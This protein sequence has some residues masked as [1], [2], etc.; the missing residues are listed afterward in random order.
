MDKIDGLKW[1]LHRFNISISLLLIIFLSSCSSHVSK[2]DGPPNFYVDESKIPNAKP[3]SEPLSKYGN[4]SSYRVFGKRYFVMK[5]GQ[6]YDEV[7]TASWYGTKFHTRRTSSGEPYNMLAMTAA[8]KSLPLP[9]YVEVTNLDNQRKIIV[10]VNDRGPFL[11]NRIIDLSYVAAKKLGML[12]RGTA[13]VRVKAINPFTFGRPT[14]FSKFLRKKT[15]KPF[16]AKTNPR[17]QQTQLVYLQVGAFRDK[18]NA[19][20]LKE[21]LAALLS[22]PVKISDPSAKG[23]FYRVQVGPIKDL[24]TAEKLTHRLKLLGIESNKIYG[25]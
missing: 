18:A 9:T 23:K 21:R 1:C 14:F 15:P 10:K 24:V 11:S 7:G 13:H 12:G 6:H 4:M 8:H 25:V 16:I 2:S 5:S 17:M 20:R 19:L 3:K 22:I